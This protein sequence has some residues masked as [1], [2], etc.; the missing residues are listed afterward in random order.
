MLALDLDDAVLHCAAGTAAGL[1]LLGQGNEAAIQGDWNQASVHWRAAAQADPENDAALY[2]LGLAYEALGRL[3]QAQFMLKSAL[4]IYE[5]V[6]TG[7]D[8]TALLLSAL[9]T[10]VSVVVIVAAGR[11]GGAREHRHDSCV[12]L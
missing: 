5:A 7:E 4:A 8:R 6:V 3:D 1:Q 10:A 11:L 2:N 12:S 9:L